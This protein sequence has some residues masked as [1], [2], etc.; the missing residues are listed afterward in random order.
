[1]IFTDIRKMYL[2]AFLAELTF[3]GSVAVPFFLEWGRLNYTQIFILEAWFMGCVFLLEIPT[4]VV[5]D[6]IGRKYSLFLS[7]LVGSVGLSIFGLFS[8]FY[9]FLLAEFILAASVAFMSGADSALVY[10]ILK[11]QK[12]EK[13]AKYIF[14]RYKIFNTLGIIVAVPVGSTVAGLMIW[15]Y[16]ANLALPFLLTCVPVFLSGIIALTIKET[17]TPKFK[18]SYIST[19]IKGIKYF[20]GHKMLKA[21][22]ADMVLV[23]STTFFMYWFYQSLLGKLGLNVGINGFVAAGFN[24]LAIIL[25]SQIK[26]I[27]KLFGIKKL[28]FLTA[29]LPGIFYL[30]LAFTNSLVFILI[31][32]FAI[33]GL[34]GLREPIF[35]HHINFYVNK[36]NRS[37]ILST[38]SM[39]NRLC[40]VVLYPIVG[41]LSD[42]SL[43]YTFLILGILTIVFAVVFRTSEEILNHK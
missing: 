32:I 35:Q 18:E 15:S 41:F 4:G 9:L 20:S 16:P 5:A 13:Q 36:K 8:N 19:G 6:R 24:L 30:G 39:L 38:I 40:M 2:F 27:E 23:S 12:K 42:I 34:R 10:E 29:I 37:T 11:R 21:L 17:K 28:L 7:G 14:S 3:F 43:E 1:M 25:L 33:T 26:P 31:A 22:A